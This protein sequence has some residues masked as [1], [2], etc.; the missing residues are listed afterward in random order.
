MSPIELLKSLNGG[1]EPSA[2]EIG[3][4]EDLIRTTKFPQGVINLMVL[5]V[6]SEKEGELPGFNYFDKIANTW[7]RAGV[8]LHLMP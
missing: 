4:L 7:A 6:N 5:M 1:I 3:M 8:K 2:S